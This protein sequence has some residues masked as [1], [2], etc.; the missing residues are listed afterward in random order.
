MNPKTFKF[1][2]L[3][4]LCTFAQGAWAQVSYV[5][6][7]WDSENKQVVSTTK[8]LSEEIAFDATPTSE[9]QY[10]VIA[11][12]T[13]KL[14]LGTENSSLHEY[15]IVQGNVSVRRLV[16]KGPN[17]H[18][19]LCDNAKFEPT[20]IYSPQGHTVYIHSQSYESAM[21]KLYMTSYDN[22]GIGG[23]YYD[24]VLGDIRAGGTIE[25]HG[26]DFEIKNV[27]NYLPAIGGSY[28]DKTCAINI[29]G[30]KI[31]AK[32]GNHAAGIGG[33][34][35]CDD[36]GIINIYDGTIEAIGGISGNDG[37]AGIGCGGFGKRG[38]I[39]IYGG[40]IKATGR[41]EAAG[42]GGTQYTD[43]ES[44]VIVIIDGGN[45]VARGDAYA[46]GI[47]CG[48][49]Q[50]GCTVTIHGGHVEAYGGI[51]A[52]GIGGGEGGNGGTVT[53][54]GGEVYAYGSDDGAGIGGGQDGKGGNVTIT[55]GT[56]F[57]KA[58]KNATGRSAIGA[59]LGSDD[60]GSLTIGDEMM[61]TAERILTAAE[62]KDGCWHRAQVLISP[63]IHNDMT[64]TLRGTGSDDTHTGHCNYCNKL[65]TAETHTFE[66]ELCNSC[67]VKNASSFVKTE[68]ELNAALTNGA[69]IVLG[70]DI[71]LS[72]EVTIDG[73]KSVTIDLYGHKLDR[74]LGE[75]NEMGS[76]VFYIKEG[77]SLTINDGSA[78][79][80]GIITGG[81]ANTG[82]GILN[83][84][85]LVFNGGTITGNRTGD[86][87]AGI[88]NMGTAT[89]NGGVIS[90]NTASGNGGGIS[91]GGTLTINDGYITDNTSNSTGGGIAN[92]ATLNLYGGNIIGNKAS[93]FGGG[94]WMGS[95]EA[96]NVKGAI[97]V[98]GNTKAGDL[99]DNIYFANN[100]VISV[101]GSLTGSSMGISTESEGTFTSGYSTHNSGVDPNTYFIVDNT[102]Y[103]F[104]SVDGEAYL[105]HGAQGSVYYVE[106]S[107]DDVNKTVVNT[108]KTLT[109]K[110]G[111]T[112]KPSEGDYKEVTSCSNDDDWFALGGFNDE[113]HE[114]YVV[115]GIVSHN[116]LNV[117]GK[118]V[119]LI[120]CDD[121]KLTLSGGI[122]LYGEK[123]LYIHSQSYG[124]SMGK[125]IAESGYADMTAGIGSDT[126]EV[127]RSYSSG[128]K[129]TGTT[130]VFYDQRI[131]AELEIHGG[132]IYAKGG[133][134]AAGIGGGKMQ[135]GCDLTIY[136][137]KVEGHCKDRHGAGIGGGDCGNG[138]TIIIYDGI[139]A[140]YGGVYG[141]GIGGGYCG[142]G[143]TIKIYGGEASAQG[144]RSGAGIGSGYAGMGVI[145][146]IYG[147]DVEAYGGMNAAGIGGGENGTNGTYVA[148]TI[149]IN[150][151]TVKAY[152]GEDGAG[153]GGGYDCD[154]ADVT[155]NGGYVEAHGDYA[156]GG[157]G[158]GIGSGTEKNI[159]FYPVH[160]GT[161]TVT[162][163]IVKAYGGVDAA[164]IGGGEDAD[165]G[166][167]IISG[168]EVYAYGNDYAAGIGGGQDG[169]GGNV[170]ITGGIVVVEAGENVPNAIGPGEDSDEYGSLTL[171]DQM[172]VRGKVNSDWSDP[173]AASSRKDYCWQNKKVRI[174][175]CTHNF[176]SYGECPVCHLVSLADNADNSETIS[177]WAGSTK[178]VVLTGRTLWKDGDWN[179]LCLPF[180]VVLEDSP[181][182]GDGV[183]VRTLS[184]ASFSE[185]TLTL[186][187]T[188]A[189]AITTLQ[190]GTP[191]IIKWTGSET[192][193]VAPVFS[194]V[195]ISNTMHDV[196]TQNVDFKGTYKAINC[197]EENKSILFLGGENTLYYPENGATIGAQRAYFA[198]NG[199]SAADVA[200]ARLLFE[201]E[202][203]TGVKEVIEV[204]GV[205]D[206]SWY[207]L[208]GVK[209]EGKPTAPGIYIC[210]GRRVVIK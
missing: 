25:I 119:H 202:E 52:A 131:P 82:G 169:D 152:G 30:G 181:L 6:R 127:A 74:G 134:N 101:T 96:F 4:L 138:G 99:A 141:A 200:N 5:E 192:N 163:G 48:D 17:V 166:T 142:N 51:D 97:T 187:F 174:E 15:Y 10:K 172:I 113:G 39:H 38:T 53:I 42:I 75:A 114:Y 206:D 139:V 13:E 110:I 129:G 94:I 124:S 65:F 156:A 122:L 117:L 86:Q 81:Y 162:G 33:S 170:T 12:T 100:K 164:G 130:T 144:G 23:Y 107:W 29:F 26:G 165:G 93:A 177:H 203:I 185:G 133:D 148:G 109:H 34:S 186:N 105:S 160:D 3:A 43:T 145:L 89:I 137:G 8:T 47:G 76:G 98:S 184:S 78:D 87:G 143:G 84:G 205:N 140:G 71:T 44:E 20:G 159:R 32:G 103:H 16:L 115:R 108:N 120:L 123:T 154:G 178:S 41:H 1:M 209:L 190:A 24:P 40:D 194:N 161:L 193:I 55:G 168:G 147:G 188:E 58:G 69:T 85:T 64:Y 118:N 95:Y 150:G 77:S 157:N 207:T 54:T 50:N 104:T 111:Y 176:G 121:A 112:D 173:V 180:S 189:E 28:L 37:G 158:A 79:E 73:N 128:K 9:N 14:Y 195:T 66:H 49:G 196:E 167:V 57:A 56:V 70:A 62:R 183:D 88:Y 153:I 208:S 132:D 92:G 19:I 90:G 199:I 31:Y 151:G 35:N 22:E 60:N 175:P 135:S 106:R 191:Y 2:I 126:E 179:T 67:G 11:S 59:G 36:F 125:L 149:T 136:G 83:L 204:N 45:V 46:A 146:E 7:S 102:A 198:L 116:T 68:A 201:E 197:T 18:L 21:G 80:S 61:V 155:I 27:E 210:G 182:A 63:C 72:N 91:N 171:G